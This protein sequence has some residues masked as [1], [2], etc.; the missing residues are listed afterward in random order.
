MLSLSLDSSDRSCDRCDVV[1]VDVEVG[2]INLAL[3]AVGVG[4]D[5]LV[6][7]L[8]D[9]VDSFRQVRVDI[10]HVSTSSG[11]GSPSI[12]SLK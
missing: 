11:N 3:R 5:L 1:S 9:R 6:S 8:I 7:G 12:F 2:H 4:H 10:V